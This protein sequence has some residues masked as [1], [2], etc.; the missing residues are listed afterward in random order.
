LSN[1]SVYLLSFTENHQK[2]EVMSYAFVLFGTIWYKHVEITIV[3][4]PS[5]I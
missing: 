4:V 2:I 1:V 5:Q 3:N